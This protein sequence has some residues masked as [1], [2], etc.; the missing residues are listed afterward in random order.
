MPSKDRICRM[1]IAVA[2]HSKSR[3][4][5]FSLPATCSIRT[6]PHHNTHQVSEHSGSGHMKGSKQRALA[7]TDHTRSRKD[8]LP[9]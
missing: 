6:D 1:T 3:E 2:S 9:K 5:S 7:C 4:S 8:R